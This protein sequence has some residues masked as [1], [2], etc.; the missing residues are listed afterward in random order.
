MTIEKVNAAFN[1]ALEEISVNQD[2][3]YSM[4]FVQH[5]EEELEKKLLRLKKMNSIQFFIFIIL[6]LFLIFNQTKQWVQLPFD[7]RRYEFLVLWG[8]IVVNGF[9]STKRY[10]K[11]REIENKLLLIGVYKKIQQ[12]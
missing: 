8:M 12:D 1:E 7:T 9:I 3:T 2:E 10:K 11:I 6:F 4:E 5:H